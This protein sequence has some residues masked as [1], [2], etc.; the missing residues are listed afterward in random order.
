MSVWEAFQHLNTFVDA[1]DPDTDV[2]AATRVDLARS[3]ST[4][5]VNSR[6]S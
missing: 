4:T 6:S 3:P 5:T 2:R 1:S